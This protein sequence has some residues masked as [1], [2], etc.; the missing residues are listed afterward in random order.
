MLSGKPLFYRKLFNAYLVVFAIGVFASCTIVKRYQ[1]GKPFV[2]KTNINLIGNFSKEEKESLLAGLEDQLDDSMQVRKLDKLLWSVMKNPPVYDSANADKSIMFMQALLRSHGYFSDSIYYDHTIKP[3]GKDELRTTVNFNVRPGKQVH[4]DSINYNLRHPDLQHITDST[5]SQALIKKGDPFAKNLI[6]NEL[7]RLTDVYRNTGYL[8]FTRDEL[9]GLWDTLD[10]SLLQPGLDPFEQLEILQKLK[11]RRENPTANLELRLRTIDS[12][13]L[14]KFYMGNVTVYPDYIT[15]TVGLLR[16]VKVVEG[17]TVIQHRNRFKA[18]IFPPNIYLPKDSLY[19]QRRYIRTINRLDL[20]GAWRTVSIDQVPRRDT[21]DFV[22]RLIPKKKYS[23]DTNVEGS[24][25]QSAFAGNLFG[26]GVNVSLQNRNFAKAAN[27][28]NSNLRYGIELGN[29]KGAGQFIQTQQV[30]FNHNI[31][32]PRFVPGTNL[33]PENFR[34]NFRTI[35]SFTAANTERRLLYNLTTING[36]WGYEYQRRKLLVNVKIPNIEYSYLVRRDSLDTLI[37]YNPS[38]RNIFTDGFISSVIVNLTLSGGQTNKLN[39]FRANLEQSGLITGLIRN[40]FLDRHLYRFI[41]LDAEFARLIR[42]PKASMAFRAFAGAGYEF[43]STRSPDKRNNLPFFKQYFSG[44]PNS[45]R[46]W[47]LRRLG[48]GSTMKEF[49]GQFGTPDRYGD[50]QLEANAEYRFPI[51]KP[52]GIK[53]NG[54]LFTDVGNVWFMKKAP[55]R[56]EEE[57]FKLSRLGKDIAIGAGGGLRV[58]FDFFVIRFDYS[59]RIKD[60]SPALSD[61]Q[62]QN[63]WFSYPFFKGAQ[64][65][66]GIGYP[67]IF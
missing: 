44:G 39:V 38:L 35:F 33:I 42:F 58:D 54:A 29:I 55:D 45:M 23:F 21:V 14:T 11:E 61:A 6:S 64:F 36:S 49:K 66:L 52:L 40:S 27:M 20:V 48:P 65:Q 59:Y 4:L 19:R 26:V 9:V 62:Y 47:A 16:K 1:P 51:G 17:L 32:F 28:T 31:Y 25:N 22:I 2:Y 3:E 57:I 60:P 67:F 8:R 43:N 7:D 12:V 41:K 56:P 30:S 10:V 15:D 34:D 53:V 18:K 50:I 37:K 5:K 46:A 13:K 24:I 63:K